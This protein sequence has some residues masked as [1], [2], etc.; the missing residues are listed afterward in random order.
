MK[1]KTPPLNELPELAGLPSDLRC[2]PKCPGWF[3]DSGTGVPTVC[4]ECAHSAYKN[5]L[6][7]PTD[8]DAFACWIEMVRDLVMDLTRNPEQERRVRLLF[9]ELA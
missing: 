5:G 2:D 6:V 1:P 4:D 9:G 7:I 8:R 3:V